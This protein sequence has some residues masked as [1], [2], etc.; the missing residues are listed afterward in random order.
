MVRK[1]NSM[2]YFLPFV[3]LVITSCQSEAEKLKSEG[4]QVFEKYKIAIKCP[5]ELKRDKKEEKLF[6]KFKAFKIYTCYSTDSIKGLTN[7]YLLQM[8]KDDKSYT[9]LEIEDNLDQLGKSMIRENVKV[10]RKY[11][12][13]EQAI[14]MKYNENVWNEGIFTTNYSYHLLMMGEKF[15]KQFMEYSYS[16]KILE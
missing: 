1:S 3:L 4:Y 13:G 12:A 2:R 16:V 11:N 8:M 15:E 6:P 9:E 5:C 7:K 14:L 10:K